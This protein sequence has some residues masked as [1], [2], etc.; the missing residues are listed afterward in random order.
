MN[1]LMTSNVIEYSNDL[2]NA[3]MSAY[4]S[5][6]PKTEEEAILIYNAS[7]NPD[8]RLKDCI[9]EIISVKDVYC[10]TVELENEQTGELSRS[11]RIVLID[12]KGVSYTC[13][14]FGIFNALKKLMAIF[15]TPTWEK[16]LKL[17]VK[18]I[19]KGTRN[20]LTLELVK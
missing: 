12:D 20:L 4:C 8:K 7:N 14:S 18:Q 3:E 17:K 19:S 15:G 6:E 5:I 2:K 13:V 10:E 1:E 16:P 11:P 9:G